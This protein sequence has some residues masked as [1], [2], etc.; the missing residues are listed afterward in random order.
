MLPPALNAG[1]DVNARSR[2]PSSAPKSYPPSSSRRRRSVRAG[3]SALNAQLD[4]KPP[5]HLSKPAFALA[6]GVGAPGIGVPHKRGRRSA[7]RRRCL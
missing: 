1:F 5:F 4:V 7:H 2:L 3:G 6:R